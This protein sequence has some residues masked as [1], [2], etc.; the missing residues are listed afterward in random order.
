[1]QEIH[2]QQVTLFSSGLY[3]KMLRNVRGFE[4]S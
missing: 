4:T 1:M 2:L 3:H